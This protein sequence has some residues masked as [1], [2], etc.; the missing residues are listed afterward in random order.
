VTRQVS[1]SLPALGAAFD[2]GIAAYHLRSNRAS[3][4]FQAARLIAAYG[5]SHRV[6]VFYE[7]DQIV[8]IRI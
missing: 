2:P 7:D 8:I 4:Q 6:N 3:L 5:R 1:L